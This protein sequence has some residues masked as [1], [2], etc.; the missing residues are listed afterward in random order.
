MRKTD[1]TYVLRMSA[2]STWTVHDEIL[3]E[4]ALAL[5]MHFQFMSSPLNSAP[6]TR[7]Y[8]TLPLHRQLNRPFFTRYMHMSKGHTKV[9]ET[10]SP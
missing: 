5:K 3:G 1:P 10:F 6:P 7:P 4:L 8:T 9:L 2:I